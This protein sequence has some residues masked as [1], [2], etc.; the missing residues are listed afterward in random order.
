MLPGKSPVESQSTFYFSKVSA[1]KFRNHEE[2][3][4]SSLD[5]CPGIFSGTVGRDPSVSKTTRLHVD[6]SFHAL[7]TKWDPTPNG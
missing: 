3:E 6:I 1:K 5:Q 7:N 4:E 2:E